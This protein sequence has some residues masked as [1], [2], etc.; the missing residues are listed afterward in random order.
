MGISVSNHVFFSRLLTYEKRIQNYINVSVPFILLDCKF[1]FHSSVVMGQ[2][3][4]YGAST[5]NCSRSAGRHSVLLHIQSVCV[6]F[7]IGILIVEVQLVLKS[8]K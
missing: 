6:S 4:L 1:E 8:E 2:V 7:I 3:D 5:F